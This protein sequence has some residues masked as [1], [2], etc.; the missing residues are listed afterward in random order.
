MKKERWKWVRGFRSLYR[1]SSKG[2]IKSL[3]K[4]M[5]NRHGYYMSKTKIIGGWIDKHGYKNVRLYYRKGNHITQKIQ[6]LVLEAFVGPRPKEMLGLHK[7]DIRL[8]NRLK[9]L[10]WGT[11]QQNMNDRE[12]NGH[13]RKGSDSVKAKLSEADIPIIRELLERYEG[14]W[15][16]L[17]KI[18]KMYKVHAAT[19]RDIRDKI[20]WQHVHN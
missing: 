1:V 2:R 5:K 15:G 11:P 19:I 13:H 18:A 9:N 7:N 3:A 10:Y 4:I 20:T 8:D 17:S 14:E 6:I 16:S 12:K